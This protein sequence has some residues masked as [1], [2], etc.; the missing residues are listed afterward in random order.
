MVVVFHN[1]WS[2]ALCVFLFWAA[3]RFILAIGGVK[4]DDK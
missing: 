3:Y 2:G 4:S 1:V